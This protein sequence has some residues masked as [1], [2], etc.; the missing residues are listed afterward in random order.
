MTKS[1]RRT[2]E[3]LYAEMLPVEQQQLARYIQDK[4]GRTR[5]EEKDEQVKDPVEQMMERT[6]PEPSQK[7]R[8]T[9]GKTQ[10]VKPP[11]RG[12]NS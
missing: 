8:E 1:E 2:L 4:F 5:D 9:L 3:R 6:W 10:I 7:L 12:D 11:S